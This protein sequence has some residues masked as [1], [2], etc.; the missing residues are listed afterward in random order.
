M[1]DLNIVAII[2]ARGGSKGIVNKN[3]ID[4]CGQPLLAWSILQ[5]QQSTFISEVYVTSD[6]PAILNVA[7]SYA[8]QAIQRPA[9]LATD[10]AS[11]EAA[12][13][14]ALETIT[15]EQGKEPDLIVFLQATS[16]L[17]EAVDIDNA[18][19]TL[20]DSDADSLF[21]A[22]VLDDLCV[23]KQDERN[24]L[25][26]VTY[27]PNNRGQRQTRAPLYL[28]NGSIY[29][30]KPS[31][32]RACNN[33]L[34]G[35]IEKSIMA[36][37]KSHEIDNYDDIQLCAYYFTQNLLSKYTT[38]HRILASEV[39]LIVY[40][41]DGVMTDNRVYVNQDGVESV[42]ANRADGLGISSIK[43]L[44]L[45]QLILSTET[46]KVVQARANKL[47]LPVIHGCSNKLLALTQYCDEHQIDPKKVIFVG[48]DMN[49]F[50]VMNFVG[51]A[52]APADAHP[53]IKAIANI[54]TTANGGQGVIREL[55]DHILQ[56]T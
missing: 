20:L 53:K 34:G 22:A 21:S 28:E 11:S 15:G 14:H 13:K 41:F 51:Y 8:A 44:N 12:L 49:D 24:G 33:R 26:G 55:A 48:N 18:I 39:D 10:T 19:Q 46:N 47:D 2:P 37:W 32:L 17:R 31:I 54:I 45:P 29:V 3:L 56:K 27:N 1:P 35:Q 6:D 40:D 43:K 16:P 9:E 23:W 42:V 52:I 25:E 38:N 5:A 36:Y 7:S 4:F 30:F 50:E